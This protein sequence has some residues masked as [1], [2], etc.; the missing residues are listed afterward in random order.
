MILYKIYITLTIYRKQWL[1]LITYFIH[2]KEM[3]KTLHLNNVNSPYQ[4]NDEPKFSQYCEFQAA[5][6]RLLNF[7]RHFHFITSLFHITMDIIVFACAQV[8]VCLTLLTSRARIITFKFILSQ[9]LSLGKG[10]LSS[11]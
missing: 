6:I 7:D 10:Y 9:L 11:I 2:E 1:Y 4:N 5:N 8:D 3:T